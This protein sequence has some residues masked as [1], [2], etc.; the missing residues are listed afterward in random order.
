MGSRPKAPKASAEETALI[1]R[2]G[3]ELDEKMASNEKRLKA[4]ARGKLG[5]KSL[6]GTA[7]DA[8]RKEVGNDSYSANATM[9]K[10]Y[11]KSNLLTRLM[12]KVTTKRNAEIGYSGERK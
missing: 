2:Q 4:I 12:N 11:S 1:R 8:T 6:L 3:M 7:A 9:R 10:Q 5:S